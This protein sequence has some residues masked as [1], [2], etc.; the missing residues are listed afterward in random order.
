MTSR[1]NNPKLVQYISTLRGCK[2][3]VVV[4]CCK[5]YDS[6]CR[7]EEFGLLVAKGCNRIDA[8]T[9]C[10]KIAFGVHQSDSCTCVIRDV[11]VKLTYAGFRKQFLAETRESKLKGKYGTITKMYILLMKFLAVP[12]TNNFREN[13]EHTKIKVTLRIN[14][15]WSNLDY[16]FHPVGRH[17]TFPV[18][19]KRYVPWWSSC[20]DLEIWPVNIYIKR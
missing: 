16:P 14:L 18:T 10:K 2:F 1:K 17:P 3:E 13:I 7:A 8:L 15:M 19:N 20:S 9:P 6:V 12:D 5:V 11:A 4:F